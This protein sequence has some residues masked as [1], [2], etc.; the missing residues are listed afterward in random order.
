VSEGVRFTYGND[1]STSAVDAVRFLVGDTNPKR[2]LLDDR[3][4]E[5]A[6]SKEPNESLAAALLAESLFGKFASQADITVGPV[7]KSYSKVA[8]LFLKKS[9]QLR[10]SATVHA[11]VSFPATRISTKLPLQQNTDLT[12]PSFLVGISDNP[13][14][15]QINEGLDH[16]RFYGFNY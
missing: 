8:E 7:S 6:I 2:P 10:D 15:V 4:I 13:F 14:A 16:A 3:E 9:Q 11:S 5:W 1:P 12:S